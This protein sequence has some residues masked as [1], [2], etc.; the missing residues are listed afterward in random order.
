[1]SLFSISRKP[2]TNTLSRIVVS[3]GTRGTFSLPGCLW[4]AGMFGVL[5]GL[6][7]NR[8]GLFLVPPFG[9]TLS[10]LLLLP[11]AAIAQPYALIVGSVAGAAVGTFVSLFAQG[12]G[13][14]V[15]AAVA[16]FAVLVL[17]RAFHPPGVALAI[18]PILLHP[19]NWFPLLV[20]L[21]F[22]VVAV[23][24]AAVLSKRV[25]GWPKYPRPLGTVSTL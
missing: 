6:E 3:W 25:S 19:G 16:A 5:A 8:I 12:L 15:V 24:S 11:D 14:A 7:A 18:Y 10:I 17:L 23:G 22:T 21:P 13:M 1:M 2:L 9:A 4:L 20:V